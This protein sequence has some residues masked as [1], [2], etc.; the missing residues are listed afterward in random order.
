MEMLLNINSAAKQSR[1]FMILGLSLVLDRNSE[2]LRKLNINV[3]PILF[4]TSFLNILVRL[5]FFTI[6]MDWQL[7][8]YFLFN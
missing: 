3:F 7:T 1:F 5:Y 6:I 4:I 2:V 8:N